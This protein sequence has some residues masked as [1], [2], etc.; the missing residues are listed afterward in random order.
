MFH[1]QICVENAACYT[2]GWPYI[3][4]TYML[5]Y[6]SCVRLYVTLW[7]VA[8]QAP[9]SM[10]FSRQEYWS[11]FPCSP[12]ADLPDPGIDLG[13]PAL[14]VDS[15]LAELPR[16]P[17]VQTAWAKMSVEESSLISGSRR[18]LCYNIHF[19]TSPYNNSKSVQVK[20]LQIGFQGGHPFL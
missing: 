14:Q 16:K 9:L 17:Q 2:L 13:S 20:A 11:G 3:G 10:G 4:C 15:L 6:L 5:S 19:L 7:T 18:E 8:H 12:P 1:R